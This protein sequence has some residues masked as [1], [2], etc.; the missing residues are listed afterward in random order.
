MLKK[1][2]KY[3]LPVDYEQIGTEF[4]RLGW[5]CLWIQIIL[6]ILPLLLFINVFFFSNYIANSAQGIDI[7]QYLS[8]L[9]FGLLIFTIFWSYRY[10]RIGK[11]IAILRRQPPQD[12]ILTILGIGLIA[13]SLC[14]LFSLITILWETG[15]LLF[16]LMN[17][18]QGGLPIVQPLGND[19]TSWISAIDMLS[20]M[21]LVL[22]LAAELTIL[23]ITIWLVFRTTQLRYN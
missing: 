14:I 5:L 23:F 2:R 11:K 1:L 16:I 17:I 8:F 9:S 21:T 12:N 6:A 15:R 19:S 7:I 10:I 22:T 20:L 4:L 13:S 18:P 3:L